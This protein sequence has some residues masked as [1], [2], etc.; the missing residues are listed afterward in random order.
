MLLDKFS[1]PFTLPLIICPPALV[2]L[3]VSMGFSGLWSK[4]RGIAFPALQRTLLESPALATNIFLGV[5]RRTLA[6]HPAPSEIRFY[7]VLVPSFFFL[8]TLSS[9]SPS[10]LETISSM[11]L[12]VSTNASAYFPSL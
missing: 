6:V 2:I 12:K 9:S 3:S 8:I 7:P 4:E 11:R 1:P 5:T 10:L